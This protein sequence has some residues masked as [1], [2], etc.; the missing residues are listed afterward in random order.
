MLQA[1]L[2]LFAERGYEATTIE[3]IAHQ[4][5]VAVGGFYQHFAS[6]QQLLL[7][8]MDSFLNGVEDLSQ[9]CTAD[10]TLEAR[11]AIEQAVRQRLLIDWAYVGAYRAWREATALN[12]ELR[13]LHAQLEQWTAQQIEHMLHT[14]LQ[15]PGARKDVDV[16]AL[17]WVVSLLFWRLAEVPLQEP[18]TVVSTITYM[19]YHALFIDGAAY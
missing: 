9:Q 19:L 3:E 6:K 10:N 2:S 4:A 13:A 8:L 16:T 17:A 14:L 5:G 7:V 12:G 1:A 15:T 18:D 11:S